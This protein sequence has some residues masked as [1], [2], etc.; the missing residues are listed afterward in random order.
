MEE[1]I[2]KFN[3]KEHLTED[4][5][6]TEWGKLLINNVKEEITASINKLIN[7]SLKLK[8]E[9]ELSKFYLCILDDI[10]KLQEILNEN[11][12]DGIYEKLSDLK[13][14]TWPTDKKNVM[15]LKDKAKEIRDG[16][17]KEINK[18]KEKIFIYNSKQANEDIYA[19][20]EILTGIKNVILTFMDEYQK[21]KKE[22]NIIDFSDIEHYALNILVTKDENENYIP[23]E[24]AKKYQEKFEEIAIDE[25]QDSNLVQE[26]I[27][28]TVSRG[29]NIFMVGDVKQSIYKFR[30]ARPE[31]FLEKYEKYLENINPNCE[32]RKIKLYENFRSRKNILDLTN[33]IFENIMSKELGDIEYNEEEFLNQG[34]EYEKIP[35]KVEAGGKAELHI[36]DT[37]DENNDSEISAEEE[38]EIE[39]IDNIEL[40]AKF[41]SAKIKSIIDNEFYVWDKKKG[42]RKAT[43]KDFAILLRSTTG[44][45]NIYEKELMKLGIPVFCDTATNYFETIEIQTIM[46]LLKVIDNPKIDIPLVTVLRSPIIGLTDNEL[47]EIRLES[48]NACFFDALCLAKENLNEGTLKNKINRFFELLED[49]QEKQEYFKL[50]ELIWDIYEKTGYY[51]YVSLMNDGAIK[52]ANLKMLFEK[53]KDYEEGSFKG[54]Y[55]FINFIDRISKNGSDMGAPKIIGENENVVRIMSIH[56]SK[57]LEFPIVFLSSTGKQFN[58]QDLNQS[59]LLH[60]D[61]GFGPKYINYE[62]KIEYNTLAKEAIK[63]KSKNELQSEEMRLLY[64]ALT[65]AREKIIITGIDKNLKKSLKDK[66]E[67]LEGNDKNKGINKFIIQKAKSYLDWLEFVSIYDNRAKDIIDI[68]EHKKTEMKISEEENNKLELKIEKENKTDDQ[69][70]KMLNWKYPKIELTKIEGKSSVSKISKQE[71]VK[72]TVEDIVPEFIKEAEK[73][74]TGAEFGTTVHLVMQKLDFK[75]EYDLEKINALL[76]ELFAKKIISNTQK[77][78]V[79]KEKILKFTQSELFKELKNAKEIH[80]EEPFYINTPVKEIYDNNIEE[81]ILIQGII[82]LYYIDKDDKLVVV[83]YKTDYVP[84]NDENYLIEKY[85]NQLELYA[86]ALNQALNKKVSKVYIYSTY[87]NKVIEIC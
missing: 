81:N 67:L 42:Y 57:G 14:K 2:E 40:E 43:F 76:E 27:L 58:L 8:K 69:V 35:L 83:D 7:L 10:D 55:N 73:S 47:V 36:I 46:N 16:I 78:A 39:I 26:Y 62:R 86:K 13:F 12:W 56:K 41:V 34:A 28:T 75:E 11:T 51:N 84:E 64:V 32:G 18:F 21:A 45:A 30:Q 33:L 70:E 25:Y 24:T 50:D 6:C 20:Y 71:K 3:L 29:N 44:V 4:F 37:Y 38:N 52:T 65:R 77:E 53:A 54:L 66:K 48:K 19:M 68:Y 59:I 9:S 72:Y 31:L 82:D 80:T 15:D 85:K 79:P 22:R 17:K 74:L 87:L 49:F 63:I 5:S 61:I 60:Q 23:T 1:Q